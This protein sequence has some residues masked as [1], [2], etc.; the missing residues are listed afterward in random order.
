M[1]VCSHTCVLTHRCP[2]VR[3]RRISL[4]LEPRLTNPLCRQLLSQ[5]AQSAYDKGVKAINTYIELGNEGLGL[6]ASMFAVPS[7]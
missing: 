4:C 3:A 6:Q 1:R 7:H 2:C 5:I